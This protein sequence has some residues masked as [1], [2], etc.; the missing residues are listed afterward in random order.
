MGTNG[1]TETAVPTGHEDNR[2]VVLITG[3][4]SGIGAATARACVDRGWRVYA[5]DIAA[6]PADIAQRCHCRE[7]DV[8]DAEQCQRV[9]DDI[10]DEAGRID[11]LV[12]NAGYAVLGPVEDTDSDAQRR[13][14]DVLVNGAVTL[15]RAVLPA[16]RE[17]GSGRIVNVTSVLAHSAYPGMGTYCAGKAALEAQTDALRMELHGTGVDAVL[18]EPAWVDTDFATSAR[19]RLPADRT[20]DYAGTYAALESGWVLD[21]GPF[22]TDP[23][24]VA[25]TIV[26][27]LTTASPRARYPVGAFAHFVRWAH[28]LPASIQDPIRRVMGRA[29]ITARRVSD[30]LG[31][32]R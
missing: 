20:E 32:F 10:L 23:E 13:Q 29:S 15:C 17:A 14:F 12:N 5:T 18:V 19:S 22:A 4:A 28:V 16:M 11:A 21:G 24:T 1:D 27:A 25:A 30:I 9:V 3:A 26:E 6:V 7:L 8:T 2:R 31:R